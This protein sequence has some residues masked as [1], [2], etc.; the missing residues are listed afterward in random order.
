MNQNLENGLQSPQR[1]RVLVVDD[2]TSVLDLYA[3]ILSSRRVCAKT[4][5]A[6]LSQNGKPSDQMEVMSKGIEFD[7]SL[8]RTAEESVEVARNAAEQDTP[9]AVAFI[10]V[11]MNNGHDGIWVAE[12]IRSLDP[13]INLVIMTGYSDVNAVDVATHVPPTDKLLYLQKP[14]NP[15]EILQFA[16]ALGAKWNV[17]RQLRRI[18]DQLKTRVEER[19]TE[20]LKVN[21]EL[22]DA[23]KI[24]KRLTITDDLTKLFNK[25]YFNKEIV[26]WVSYSRNYRIP[27]SLLMFDIDHFKKYNDSHG[28][29]AGD[30][31]LERIGILVRKTLRRQGDTPFSGV[32]S[33]CRYGGEEFAIILP[34]TDVQGAVAVGE[35]LRELVEMETDVTISVGAA[36][37]DLEANEDGEKLIMRADANLYRAKE[38]G[39][40]RVCS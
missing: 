4:A 24:L 1:L 20:L 34:R 22:N 26:D 5:S 19:T 7:L 40:N 3:R 16:M 28:H 18:C 9:F 23:N 6:S 2:E 31:L 12:K 8:C 14:I 36:E 10:D 27:L 39:R 17:E 38:M 21:A 11:H 37:I 35:R 30:Q 32:E 13:Y 25:R 33:V 29:L 15:Q